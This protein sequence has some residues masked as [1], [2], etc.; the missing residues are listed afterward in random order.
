MLHRI[1]LV[2]TERKEELA[3]VLENIP[4]LVGEVP[5][6]VGA[7]VYEDFGG[8]SGGY[9]RM[10]VLE[11]ADKNAMDG[12]AEHAAHVPI[13]SELR[14]LAEMIVFDHEA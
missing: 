5:G 1:V 6:L 7:K 12:W 8:R 13:R 9:D 4:L 14:R 10:F 3:E 11:F 2:K